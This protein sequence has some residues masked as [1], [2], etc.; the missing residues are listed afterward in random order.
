MPLNTPTTPETWRA[1]WVVGVLFP[2]HV[3]LGVLSALRWVRSQ[4]LSAC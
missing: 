2:A 3:L 4:A 1:W